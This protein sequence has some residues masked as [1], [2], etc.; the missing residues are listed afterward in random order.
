MLQFITH[1]NVAVYYTLQKHGRRAPLLYHCRNS[2]RIYIFFLKIPTKILNDFFAGQHF[3]AAIHHNH[4][5]EGGVADVFAY[6]N[7]VGIT[8]YLIAGLCDG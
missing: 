5:V 8:T 3:G 4:F 2:L 6:G 1:Y 7:S